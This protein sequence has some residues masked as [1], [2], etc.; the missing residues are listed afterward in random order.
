VFAETGVKEAFKIILGLICRY[1]NKPRTIRLRDQWVPMDPRSW[2]ED[3]D[4]SISVGMGT[5]DNQQRLQNAML[6]G[7]AQQAAMAA[8]MVTP[9]NLM[10]TATE[11]T[12]AM[13]YKNP[14]RFFSKP[15]PNKPPP[16][17]PEMAKVQAQTQADQAKL[18]ADGQIKAQQMQMEAQI[19]GQKLQ[20]EGQIETQNMQQEFALK[21]F[22]IEAEMA[23]KREQLVAELQL[24]REQFAAELQLKERLGVMSAA[25]EAAA[26]SS[27]VRM[28]GE[29]G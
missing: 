7:Q 11:L 10:N 23:L 22:Q 6:L 5:G 25:N 20:Q 3:M 24:K 26:N 14:E 4:V 12:K 15:D 13:G 8:G 19:S 1:Q 16:P 27:D 21:R 28:G 29:P 17:S 9:E 18:Q 2:N